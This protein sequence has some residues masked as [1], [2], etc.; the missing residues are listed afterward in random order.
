MRF[1]KTVDILTAPITEAPH[2]GLAIIVQ[3]L[4][5]EWAGK[6]VQALFLSLQGDTKKRRKT[7][8]AMNKKLKQRI[9]S[10]YREGCDR[11]TVI[12]LIITMAKNTE[13]SVEAI[14]DFIE[15][16]RKEDSE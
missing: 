3:D 11:K 10:L 14:E 4:T 9:F 1:V 15:I 5:G 2:L 8:M 13:D 6:T 16:W 12:R 7:S